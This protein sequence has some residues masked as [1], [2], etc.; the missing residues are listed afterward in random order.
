MKLLYNFI[1]KVERYIDGKLPSKYLAQ[2]NPN[3]KKEEVLL[4]DSIN[5]EFFFGYHDRSPFQKDGN[6]ILSHRLIKNNLELGYFLINEGIPSKFNVVS[7]SNAYSR[8]QGAMLQWDYLK[9]NKTISFNTIENGIAKNVSIDIASKD[10]VKEFDFPFYCM[11]E[12]CKFALSCNFFQL[13]RMRPGYG[14]ENIESNQKIDIK[15]DGIWIIDREKDSLLL[16]AS[17]IELS[18]VAKKKATQ[19][20]YLN[21]LS[22]SPN[23]K[24]IVWFLINEEPNSRE[25]IF[26]GMDL[27]NKSQIFNIESQRLTSHFCWIDNN[28]IFTSNRDQ[29]LNWKY[30]IYNL[31]NGTREDLNLKPKFDGHPMYNSLSNQVIIDTTPDSNRFQHLLSIKM[32]DLSSQQLGKWKSPLKFSGPD[33]CDLHPRWKEDATAVSIDTVHEDK[34]CQKIIFL[35]I[36][37]LL[38]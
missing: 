37:E 10:L 4:T 2:Y 11:S 21:H 33:R 9:D 35:D 14:I 25:I 13:A 26:Q 22:F 32:L 29:N 19:K 18:E 28:R 23:G 12:D 5:S 1:S 27:S 8:Q 3:I 36:N 20:T 30:S 38:A 17:Y 24:K 34:R 15:N 31:E 7:K 6:L 16:L